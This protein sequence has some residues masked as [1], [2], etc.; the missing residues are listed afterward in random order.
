[1][2]KKQRWW[3]TAMA[4]VTT[5]LLM[6]NM[7]L[8]AAADG[9]ALNWYCV[10]TKDHTQPPADARLSFVEEHGGV[11]ID[12]K[13]AGPNDPDKVVY[14]TFDA[15]YEN[16]NVAR[17]LDTLQEESVP[18]AFFILGHL[19]AD[20]PALVRR[21]ADEG[22]LV[23]N[24]TFS[25]RDMSDVT[26][27]V[28]QE[29]LS[30][31]EKTCLECA[32]V[33]V[34]KYFRPPEGRFDCDMLDAASALGYT[35]VFWSFAYADWDNDH[36]PTAAAAK[37][38]I[39]S[40]IHNGAVLLLHP[41]SATN[42]EILGD[43]IRTL[44]AD[45]YRFGTLDELTAS[46]DP[47]NAEALPTSA[48]SCETAEK[49]RLIYHSRKNDR[50]EIALSF[51]D[52]PH[53]YYT[54]L[55]LDILAEYDIRATFF[56]VGENVT[57]YPAAAEAVAAAGHEVGNHTFSHRGFHRMNECEMQREIAACE[58]AIAS[59]AECRPHFLRPPEGEM[60]DTLRR[61]VS[62]SDYR[63]I[64]WDVDTRDWAHT[65][66]EEICQHILDTVQAGD[67]VLMHDFIGHNSP[68]PEALRLVIPRLLDKGYRFV[69]VG[70]LVD[71]A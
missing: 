37:Q 48:V 1:M 54:P 67:I 60:N 49:D 30:R 63:I 65:P 8:S 6:I 46:A 31:L 69:T 13:H 17:V 14:L 21:M 11:Y 51:D 7:I 40:N 66:P 20:D 68:T 19:A 45:G 36:Q 2:A 4:L 24:H 47:A 62:D 57:Y 52:G 41:T 32:G 56:M 3:R 10:R 26:A 23:C 16:G 22:H 53:P 18:G 5:A 39:L 35:T 34:A 70:E 15:G 25:H 42:A 50:M 43:V 44:K 55:I 27:E 28:L 29:E 58:E 33:T 38:K 71:G 61:V 64:L 12:H 59:V 9:N